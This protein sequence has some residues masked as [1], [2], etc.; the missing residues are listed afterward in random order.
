MATYVETIVGPG[1][2]VVHVG[3]VSLLSILPSLF[4]GA[5]LVLVAL[6]LLVTSS[7]QPNVMVPAAGVLAVLGVLT[8]IAA[9]IRRNSTELAVTNRRVIAKFGFISRR[10]IE[11]NLT[12]IESVRVEQSVMGRLFDFGSLVIVGTGSSLDPIPFIA[13]PIAFR[14][15]IQAATDAMPRA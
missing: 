7:T 3:R 5:V 10:T 1:E 4:I 13:H 12:K 9:I 2:Q 6:G 14:Q 11:M 8:F 15:A